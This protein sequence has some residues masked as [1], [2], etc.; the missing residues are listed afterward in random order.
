MSVTISDFKV[1]AFEFKD[2]TEYGNSK[3][4]LFSMDIVF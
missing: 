1:Q 4:C 3:L 2:P